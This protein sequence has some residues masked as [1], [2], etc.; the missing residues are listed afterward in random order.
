MEG[1][2]WPQLLERVAQGW[3]RVVVLGEFGRCGPPPEFMAKH[4][5]MKEAEDGS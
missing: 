5:D 1:L 4:R 2:L 3:R